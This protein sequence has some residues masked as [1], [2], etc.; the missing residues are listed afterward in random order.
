MTG[1]PQKPLL[2]GISGVK[3]SGKTTLMVKLIQ[4]LSSQGLKVASIKHDAH[5]FEADTPGTDSHRHKAAGAFA[6]V[7]FDSEKLLLVKDGSW[8]VEDMLAFFEGADIVLLEG[9]KH[10]PYPKIE[11]LRQGGAFG[12]EAS[13]DDRSARQVLFDG[14]LQNNML[15]FKEEAAKGSSNLGEQVWNVLPYSAPDCEDRFVASMFCD[16]EDPIFR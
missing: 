4:A 2:V 10:T 15:R 16:W 9:A 7:I 12:V 13:P 6:S 1:T 8:Q 5:H 11:V 14:R 3:N